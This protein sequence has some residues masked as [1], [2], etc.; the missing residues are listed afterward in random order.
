VLRDCAAPSAKGTAVTWRPVHIAALAE[1]TA[2]IDA[3]LRPGERIVA[4]GAHMLHEG[5]PVRVAA[6]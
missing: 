3:G 4:M 5:Q 1:E 6:R 2:T